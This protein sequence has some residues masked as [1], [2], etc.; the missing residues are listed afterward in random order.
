MFPHRS[1]KGALSGCSSAYTREETQK[2]PLGVGVAAGSWDSQ[3]E[4][5]V[6]MGVG[7]DGKRG[8]IKIIQDHPASTIKNRAA[9]TSKTILS[10]GAIV[11]ARIAMTM[12]AIKI[13]ATE[14]ICHHSMAMV[15]SFLRGIILY[16]IIPENVKCNGV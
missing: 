5:L 3:P 16:N 6:G 8:L 10:G 2:H 7:D 12:A 13:T 14:I 15:A 9:T 1:A 4:A 11:I